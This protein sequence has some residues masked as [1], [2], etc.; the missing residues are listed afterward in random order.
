MFIFFTWPRCVNIDVLLFS[1]DHGGGKIPHLETKLIFLL[2]HF[3][4]TGGRLH[5]EYTE[6]ERVYMYKLNVGYEP[7]RGEKG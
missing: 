2:S 4:T 7:C 5:V 6:S 3:P 1:N